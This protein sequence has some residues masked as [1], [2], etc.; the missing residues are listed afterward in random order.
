MESDNGNYECNIKPSIESTIHFLN[1]HDQELGQQTRKHWEIPGHCSNLLFPTSYPD[2]QFSSSSGSYY[3]QLFCNETTPDQELVKEVRYAY[4]KVLAKLNNSSVQVKNFFLPVQLMKLKYIDP[5]SRQ[6]IVEELCKFLSSQE[7]LRSVILEQAEVTFSDL[8]CILLSVARNSLV[9]QLYLFGVLRRCE[10]PFKGP[11]HSDSNLDHLPR[12]PFTYNPGGRKYLRELN[13]IKVEER[14]TNKTSN[15]TSLLH[16]FKTLND[17]D[18]LSLIAW[19][20]SLIEESLAELPE[21]GVLVHDDKN[22]Q[23][24]ELYK[25]DRRA[26]VF[27]QFDVAVQCD[28]STNVTDEIC[29]IPRRSSNSKKINT[30]VLD[31][32][33]TKVKIDCCK[34]FF[35]VNEDSEIKNNTLRKIYMIAL[36]G[37]VHL[38]VLSVNYKLLGDGTGDTL[39]SIGSVTMG[40]LKQLELLCQMEDLPS[41]S[42]KLYH[43]N[44]CHAIPDHIWGKVKKYCPY[45]K[46][47]M[48]C[49][50]MSTYEVTKMFVT[51]SIP[52]SSIHFDNGFC[53]TLASPQIMFFATLNS[54]SKTFR[55]S[56]EHIDIILWHSS[57]RIDRSLETVLREVAHLKSFGY[58]GPLQCK[59]TINN[60]CDAALRPNSEILNFTLMVQGDPCFLNV[61]RDLTDKLYKQ[62]LPKFRSR[63]INFMLGTHS[64]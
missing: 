46:V 43:E 40:K 17:C 22:Q 27:T 62:Y 1:K 64:V 57:G 48:V 34:K 20:E 3:Y 59:K 61:A 14:K 36:N 42:S 15:I 45:L 4:Y 13:R 41:P 44:A 54:L 32:A 16:T 26:F 25:I 18:A 10:I 23:F 30:S 55:N 7:N 50:S 24:D 33:F 5:Y 21:S 60:L 49:L 39:M 31:D 28:M 37:L 58:H 51:K 12:V 47:R 11:L 63:S 53:S 52:L 19:I 29:H 9:K 56:L 35:K 8:C 38:T 6:R 2:I